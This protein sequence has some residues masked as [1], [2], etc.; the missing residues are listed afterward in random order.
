MP[1]HV[2]SIVLAC[3]CIVSATTVFADDGSLNLPTAIS[4]E[5][6]AKA[7]AKGGEAAAA[8]DASIED[9]NLHASASATARIDGPITINGP[10]TTGGI[11]DLGSGTA[12]QISTGI[13]NIQQGVQATAISF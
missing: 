5:T 8:A 11:G 4:P 7:S 1:R 3:A 12:S 10:V 13:G 6:L 2:L 9:G